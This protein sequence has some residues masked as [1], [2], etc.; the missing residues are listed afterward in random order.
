M[1][2]GRGN[3]PGLNWFQRSEGHLPHCNEKIPS[4]CNSWKVLCFLFSFSFWSSKKRAKV[5]LNEKLRFLARCFYPTSNLFVMMALR[6]IC[7]C[8]PGKG[9]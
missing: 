6:E 9:S 8:F 7:L 4:H 2:E 3:F 5:S 1:G